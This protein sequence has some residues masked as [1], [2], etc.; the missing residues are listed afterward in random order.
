MVAIEIVRPSG[1]P[2]VLRVLQGLGCVA[3]VVTTAVTSIVCAERAREFWLIAGCLGG[4]W[5]GYFVLCWRKPAAL[6]LPTSLLMCLVG[7]AVISENLPAMEGLVGLRLSNKLD[8]SPRLAFWVMRHP[9]SRTRTWEQFGE[10]PLFYRYQPGRVYRERP[11]YRNVGEE[12]EAIVDD[13]GFLN[14]DR[15]YYMR[16]QTI[17]VFIA[18][19][20]VMQG[21]GMPGV[22]EELRPRVPFTVYSLATGSYS[23]RQKVE[24]LKLFGLPKRPRYVFIEFYAGNDAS[25]SIEDEICEKL[26][27]DYQCRFDFTAMARGLSQNAEYASMGD[28]GD[29]SPLMESVRSLRSNSMTLAFA[30][31]IAQKARRVVLNAVGGHR[32]PRLNSEAI[33]LPGFTHY[34]IAPQHHLD[35]IKKGLDLTVKGY[36]SL[37]EPAREL[38]SQVAILY[39]PTSY[40]IYRE[41]LRQEDTDQI[42]D[43]IS[44]VQRQT[45]AQYARDNGLWFCDL[46]DA[47]REEVRR[48][49]RGLFGHY[50]GT[51]WSQEGTR[52]AGQVIAECLNRLRK[53][54]PPHRGEART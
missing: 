24:A 12:Y 43:E 25:E 21:I 32:Q 17:E 41:V 14:A 51:H 18:G 1:Q 37:A 10:D 5:S 27:R 52:V 50:D 7:F 11:D 29:F 13:Q 35:W 53:Q 46:T 36:D 8:L 49:V 15:S 40:E 38:G 47:F 3:A 34:T 4:L 42:A 31:G 6:L 9:E 28:F 23:P 48:G 54:H 33:T 44:R 2:S 22:I 20:S 39:N 45:L 26:K 30:T 19:D 16:H